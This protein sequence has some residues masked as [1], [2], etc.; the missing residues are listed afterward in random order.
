V[1]KPEHALRPY[2]EE[3]DDE[4]G[5]IMGAWQ[6]FQNRS[7][8]YIPVTDT[9]AANTAPPATKSSG[10]SRVGGGRAHIDSPYAITQN[11]ATGSTHTFPSIGHRAAATGGSGADQTSSRLRF[12]DESPPPSVSSNVALGQRQI[13]E[14]GNALPHN[15]ILPY[16]V[17]TKSQTAIIENVDAAPQAHRHGGSSSSANS[18]SPSRANRFE[19]SGSA[20]APPTSYRRRSA[21]MESD[22]DSAGHSKKKWYQLRRT[23]AHSTEGYSAPADE[24]PNTN[25]SLLEPPTTPTPGKSFVVIRKQSPARSLQMASGS[26]SQPATPTPN[27]ISFAKDMGPSSS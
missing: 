13:H 27:A 10:F 11:Q 14:Q 12:E 25:T 19:S 6:P 26:G 3:S 23:R 18:R 15:A 8:G 5:Y 21:T 1:L 17:R 24:S 16:H 7:S 22:D 2:R 20:Q 4:T 9:T